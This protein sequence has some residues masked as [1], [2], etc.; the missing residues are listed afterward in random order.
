MN[1][2]WLI[3]WVIGWPTAILLA[4][5]ACYTTW[6]VYA[7][8]L[9]SESFALHMLAFVWAMT[10]TFVL[11]SQI[12]PFIRLMPLHIAFESVPPWIRLAPVAI[13][14]LAV[15]GLWSHILAY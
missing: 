5:L 6:L 9:W 11:W 8:V 7:F 12:P 14:L 13:G 4:V 3:P 10:L 15:E 2:R 1:Y